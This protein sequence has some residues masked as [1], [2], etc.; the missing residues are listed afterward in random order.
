MPLGGRT[1]Q[2]G[3]GPVGSPVTV[4][5]STEALHSVQVKN[6][7]GLNCIASTV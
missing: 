4:F 5:N 1:V 2:L 3:C 7:S 6:G